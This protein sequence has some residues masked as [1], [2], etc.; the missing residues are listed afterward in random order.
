MVG[1]AVLAWVI[2]GYIVKKGWDTRID[3]GLSWG[4]AGLLGIILRP[5]LI[6][7]L[8]IFTVLVAI[9]ASLAVKPELLQNKRFSLVRLGQ[10]FL[11]MAKPEPSRPV[12]PFT[13]PE[14][15]P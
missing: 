14:G 5:W 7:S 11:P 12:I 13:L 1:L 8:A 2:R 10:A 6:T 9:V 15:R 3:D 4:S